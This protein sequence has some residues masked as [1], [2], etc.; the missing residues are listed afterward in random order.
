MTATVSPPVGPLE[1]TPKQHLG[2]FADA[3]RFRTQPGLLTISRST[4]RALRHERNI[5]QIA[6]PGAGEG[7][8][9]AGKSSL[10]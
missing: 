1:C 10:V 8:Q 6:E 9:Q 2:R 4:C 7:G 3:H 5:C